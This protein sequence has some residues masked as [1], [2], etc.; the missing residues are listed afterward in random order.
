MS[1]FDPVVE[2]LRSVLPSRMKGKTIMWW[3]TLNVMALW[4]YAM[5]FD[6]SLDG[7]I[8]AIYIAALGVFAGSKGYELTEI[9]KQKLASEKDPKDGYV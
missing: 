7:S 1:K 4:W 8:A 5:L 2:C 6:K 3:M 9:R